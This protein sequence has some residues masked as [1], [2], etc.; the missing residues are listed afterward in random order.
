[1]KLDFDPS[2]IGVLFFSRGRGTGH[3]I[4]DIAIAQELKKLRHDVDI[5]FASYATG[6]RTFI[7]SGCDV[8][9]LKLPEVGSDMETL[10]R[11]SRLIGRMKPQLVVAHEEFSVAPAAKIFRRP[12]SFIT[13]W[14]IEPDKLSMHCLNYADEILFIDNKGIFEEPSYLE[15]KVRYMGPALRKSIY[16][17]E[18]CVSARAELGL[19]VDAVIIS[20]IVHPGRRS[21]SVA[22]IFDL[23][24]PAFDSLK[25]SKKRLIW[26]EGNDHVTLRERTKGRTDVIVASSFVQDE[27]EPFDRLM[28]A[29][30]LAVT[31]ANRNIVLELAA[32]GVPSIS[33]SHGYNRIDEIRTSRIDTNITIQA[34]EIDSQALARLIEKLQPTTVG[35]SAGH[36]SQFEDGISNAAARLAETL[37]RSPQTD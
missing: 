12:V 1:M 37:E 15:G 3:A 25:T 30:D 19:P 8:I 35:D 36:E 32:L 34:N 2:C 29:S 13:D 6:A 17:R 14:F 7:E 11:S 16:S 20:V 9:D 22:P 26:L 21:E 27:R 10:I 5:R 23:L 24:I 4:P 33:I 28:V 18:D 31:K